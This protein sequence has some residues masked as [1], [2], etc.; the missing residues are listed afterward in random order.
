MI[1]LTEIEERYRH[2]VE[3]M[4]EIPCD[5]NGGTVCGQKGRPHQMIRFNCYDT[6]C[7]YEGCE[8]HI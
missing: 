7:V 3:D 6:L 4:H 1:D 2:R 5:M 8:G